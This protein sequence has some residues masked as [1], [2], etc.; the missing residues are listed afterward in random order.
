MK[1]ISKK[2]IQIN[3][4]TINWYQS[5]EISQ[6]KTSLLFVHGIA[7]QARHWLDL[8]DNLIGDYNIYIIDRPGYGES[9]GIE[10]CKMDSYCNI[11]EEIIEGLNIITPYIYIGHSL[12]SYLGLKLA[13]RSNNIKKLILI[14]PFTHYTVSSKM[15]TDSS[16][17]KLTVYNSSYN[18]FFQGVD[19]G[20]LEKFRGDIKLMDENVIHNDFCMI[21]EDAISDKEL[22]E[23]N[24]STIAIHALDD[25]VISVRKVM[26]MQK[27]MKK[28]KV[29]TIKLGGHNL[30]ISSP[31]D[32]NKLIEN[33]IVE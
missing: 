15:L 19:N 32:T 3:K 10:F 16:Y 31:Q 20:I 2:T 18:S 25:R 13:L 24:I 14:A 4:I 22:G 17:C 7:S 6:E 21:D 8:V 12:G 11:L 26:Q 23:V 33:C 5:T 27:H 30:Y 29:F 28:C 9:D 1:K